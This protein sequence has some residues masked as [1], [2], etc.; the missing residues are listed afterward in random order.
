MF[1]RGP[2]EALDSR[3]S[4]ACLTSAAIHFAPMA[5]SSHALITAPAL[6]ALASGAELL[7][8]ET[9]LASA[10]PSERTTVDEAAEIEPAL[11][12]LLT[13]WPS[14]TLRRQ[15]RSLAQCYTAARCHFVSAEGPAWAAPLSNAL[16]GFPP[17]T[18]SVVVALPA[19][20]AA[21]SIEVGRFLDTLRQGANAVRVTVGATESPD[22]WIGTSCLDGFVRAEPQRRE[23]A[24]LQLCSMLVEL[25]APTLLSAVSSDEFL[26]AA[27]PAS[28]PSRLIEFVWLPAVSQLICTEP[29]QLNWLHRCTTVVSSFLGDDFRLKEQ[30]SLMRALRAHLPESVEL[31]FAHG[32]GLRVSGNLMAATLSVYVLCRVR[33]E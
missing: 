19:Q 5:R 3:G 25:Q 16:A 6:P 27:G 18:V 22:S 14:S 7:I 26:A 12:M 17:A 21:L 33:S 15:A 30:A 8:I 24:G 20:T 13:V 28:E 2:L 31:S 9:R 11:T 1:R 23:I 32:Q 4:V 10:S 29:A